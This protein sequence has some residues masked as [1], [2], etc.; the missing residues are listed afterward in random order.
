M[1]K[2]AGEQEGDDKVKRFAS[3]GQN[4]IAHVTAIR[5]SSL[6]N[7]HVLVIAAPMSD[8]TEASERLLRHGLRVSAALLVAGLAIALIAS[9]LITGSLSRL[10]AEAVHF[11]DLDFVEGAQVQ[12]RIKEINMLAGA[13]ASARDAIRTF[14]LYVP[15]ELVRKIVASGLFGERGAVRQ[16]VTVLFTD[17]KDFTTI[18]ERHS[19]EEVVLGLSA[20]F[21][22]MNK[23]VEENAGSIV[24]FLGN[25]I[26][27]MWN[28]PVADPDH[29]AHGCRCALDL[30]KAVADSMPQRPRPA[31]QNCVTRFGLHP[32]RRWS[33][34]SAR[35]SAC[36]TR[37]WATP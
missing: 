8:F 9:R 4:Y 18:S 10:T 6:H 27:A 34:A 28:A 30:R 33:A 32:G 21:D 35:E 19:P 11:G 1:R 3:G 14:A 7:E 16:E 22:L 24:Q 31:R 29:V 23:G 5:F 36:N 17:I 20:Y 25:S 15:R 12:S 2:L 13:L 26:Y 37:R